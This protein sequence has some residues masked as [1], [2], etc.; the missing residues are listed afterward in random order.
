MN[1]GNIAQGPGAIR[2]RDDV[3]AMFDRIVPHYDLMNR[4]MTGGRDV[5]WRKLAVREAF[6]HHA[7]SQSNVLD[8]A[9][10]TGDLAMALR[11]AGAAHVTGLDFSAAMLAEAARKDAQVPAGHH[12]AWV[13]GDAMALP[14]EDASFDAV[15]VGFG[16]RNLPDYGAALREIWRVLRPGGT[17][18]CLE[19]T[20]LTQPV[21]RSAFDWYFSRVVPLVGGLLSGDRDAYAYLP[22]SAAAFPDAE[23]LGR[24]MIEAGFRNVRYLRLGMGTVAIHVGRKPD[25]TS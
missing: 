9:T 2:P 21:L 5:A 16:L 11:D 23:A 4:V 22:A 19:T 15:T 20:P 3:K 8:I 25:A 14:I 24:L 6:R 18:V 7:H 1:A 12:I 17:F 10:G 13:E